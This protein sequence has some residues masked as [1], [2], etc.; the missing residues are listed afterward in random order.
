V[1]IT[2]T[3]TLQGVR[4]KINKR[5]H[6]IGRLP[7]DGLHRQLRDERLPT[8]LTSDEEGE[9]GMSL[10]NGG[11]TDLLTTLGSW[12]PLRRRRRTPSP[13]PQERQLFSADDEAVGGSELL[14][15]TERSERV[16]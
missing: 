11:S 14:D 10:L 3:D 15:L 1:K 7:G 5:E 8:D 16:R 9:D 12:M 6:G 2:A 4:D 13:R